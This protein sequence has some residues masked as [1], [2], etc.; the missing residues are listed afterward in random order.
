M[1]D[2]NQLE[3]PIHSLG[4][5]H[6]QIVVLSSGVTQVKCQILDS[7]VKTRVRV[8]EH[9]RHR[10]HQQVDCLEV[11]QVTKDLVPLIYLERKPQ[12]LDQVVFLGKHR[13]HHS[14]NKLH[15]QVVVAFSVLNLPKILARSRRRQLLQVVL[16]S[17]LHYLAVHLNNQVR[18]PRAHSL[19]KALSSSLLVALEHRLSPKIK[20][21]AKH[22]NRTSPKLEESLIFQVLVV[23]RNQVDWVLRVRQ[24][25]EVA[26]LAKKKNQNSRHLKTQPSK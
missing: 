25:V 6:N 1:A 12:I 18:H 4:T 17:P 19:V 24:A 15:H 7:L 11:V 10:S 21:Q 16:D 9:Q 14:S 20:L 8:P 3:A 2:K 13:N 23:L 22:Q 5:K 26:S